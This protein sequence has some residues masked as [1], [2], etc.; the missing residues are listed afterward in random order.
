MLD[1]NALQQLSLNFKGE[2]ITPGHPGYIDSKRIWNGMI[3]KN[4]AVI[5]KCAD[6]S[7]IL[8]ALEFVKNST[9]PLS[10]RAGGH[11][12][13]GFSVN[14]NGAV[15]DL[16]LMREVQIKRNGK[17]TAIVQGG[18]LMRDLDNAAAEHGLAVPSGIISHTGVAGLTLG[19]GFG[20]ISRKF[21]L[22]IDSLL[23]AEIITADGNILTAS[24]KENSDL[25]WG[26]RGGGG[27]F[28]VA[29]SFEFS[30]DNLGKEVF[31]GLIIRPFNEAK[32]Y[33]QFHRDYVRTLPDEMTVWSI[34]RHAPPLP[35]LPEDVHGKLVVISPF[36]YTG[37]QQAGEKLLKPLIDQVK[38]IAA[39]MGMHPWTAWQS[40]F[41]ALNSHYFRNYWKSHHIKDFSDNFID[42][43][44]TLAEDLPTPLCEILLL[45]MEGKPSRI[46]DDATAYSY[47]KIP[48]IMNLHTRWENKADDERCV[49]WAQDF[50]TKTKPYSEGVYVN[51]LS[52]EGAN[53]V[54]DAYSPQIWKRL[55]EVKRKYDPKNLFNSNQNIKPD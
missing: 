22:S 13:A 44:L 27:N 47:R 6:T 3:E 19:G 1:K 24:E 15:I 31:A 52:N 46:P 12:I 42:T 48:F 17:S 5:L 16:S 53:R 32:K 14:N 25:F 23:S 29:T 4:P 49:N 20:W 26:I 45:H 55:V 38:P 35:F 9:M 54:R 8:K 2:I 33:L 40:G 10:I 43:V 21:G 7:D 41:D 37:D 51:F 34:I 18:A 36:V 30:C 28:G 50:F 11:S 39:V